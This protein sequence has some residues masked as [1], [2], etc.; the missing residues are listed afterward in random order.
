MKVRLVS[1]RMNLLAYGEYVPETGELT[2]FAGSTVSDGISASKTFRG[3]KSIEK[4]R[5]GRVNGNVLSENVT[6]KSPSTAANFITGG[7][8]NGMRLWKTE[9]GIAIGD[10]KER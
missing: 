8:S 7:S 2:V 1:K 5:E 6:F 4:A 9:D 3:K 10:L